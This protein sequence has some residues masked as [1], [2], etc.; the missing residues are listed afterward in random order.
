MRISAFWSC[1]GY[2]LF[3]YVKRLQIWETN[4]GRDA[5][6]I[7]ERQG[8]PIA[9]LSNPRYADMFWDSYDLDIVT[10]DAELRQRL[11]SAEFW[12]GAEPQELVYRSRAFGDVVHPVLPAFPEP[13]RLLTRGLYLRIGQPSPWDWVMLWL[14]RSVRY[15]KPKGEQANAPR[16]APGTRA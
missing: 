12:R 15:D 10:E 4:F 9:I 14:R 2:Q 3:Y 11:A 7:I 13:G 5:G 16:S 1:R 6:W 8:R